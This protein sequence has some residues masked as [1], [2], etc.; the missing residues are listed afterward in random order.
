MPERTVAHMSEIFRSF[1]VI[2]PAFIGLL[3]GF[4]LNSVTALIPVLDVALAPRGALVG[5]LSVTHLVL[6]YAALLVLR[7][8]ASWWACS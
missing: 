1:A 7:R 6:T 8:R 2:F 4:S 3:P 5:T